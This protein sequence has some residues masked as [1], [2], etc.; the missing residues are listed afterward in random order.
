M[1]VSSGAKMSSNNKIDIS[2]TVENK[3]L[4]INGHWVPAVN[5]K[6]Y[7]CINPCNEEY[8]SQI[9]DAGLNDVELAI[10]AADAAFKKDSWSAISPH[11]RSSLLLKIAELIE[12]DSEELAY[13]ESLNTGMTL[14]LSRMWAQAA[15]EMFRY[16]AGWPTKMFGHTNPGTP[17]IVNFTLREPVGVCGLITPWNAPLGIAVQKIAPAL[18]CGNTVIIK[19]S[20]LTPYTTLKLAQLIEEA[21]LPAGVFNV[22]TSLSNQVGEALVAH[23]KI[24]LI[25]FTGS[26]EVGKKILAQAA[27]NLK[28]VIL[29]LGGKSP[30]IIF[31]D[32]DLDRAL[33]TA[34][35][36]FCCNAGQICVA[37]SRLFVHKKIY[38]E[39][40]E[41]IS[42]LA[43]S[44][45]IGS[46]FDEKTQMGPLISKEHFLRISEYV[47]IAKREG[48]TLIMGGPAP[49]DKG[50]Y[51]KPTIFINVNNTMRI[52]KE[53]IFGPVLCIIPFEDEADVIMQ[54]NESNYGLA[55]AVW[56]KD[57]DRAHRMAKALQS[58]YVW[59]NTFFEADSISPF[60]GYKQS[61][62]GRELGPESIDSFT[63]IK[64][65]LLRLN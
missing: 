16:Y 29:E 31:E 32:A 7:S 60:G 20:P 52:A 23:D 27:T 51:F 15:A 5:H 41:K 8:I 56:T 25:S 54:S 49:T 44:L 37:G 40:V 43:A 22:L 34:V 28:K 30:N 33:P 46:P 19:P 11:Q 3:N 63:Q 4:F 36:A 12:R 39:V 2:K 9:A 17:S 64:S 47:E 53:E 48:A 50:F 26:T 42:N 18:A 6:T 14:W 24:N 35:N 21:K 58:G 55:A 10:E 65:V 62:I 1:D 45:Q 57:I 61:G 38:D 59:L 13:L